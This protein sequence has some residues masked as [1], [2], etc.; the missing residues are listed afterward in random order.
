MRS[1][2]VGSEIEP[3]GIQTFKGEEELKN[4]SEMTR[5]SQKVQ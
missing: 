3:Q 2:K 4:K 1:I 5:N